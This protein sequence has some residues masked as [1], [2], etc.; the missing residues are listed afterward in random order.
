MDQLDAHHD[1]FIEESSGI[2]LVEADSAHL[3]CQMDDDVRF[4]LFVESFHIV[5]TN[6]IVLRQIGDRYIVISL[7]LESFNEMFPQEAFSAGEGN[8]FVFHRFLFF[9]LPHPLVVAC[10]VARIQQ[11]LLLVGHF[12]I[13]GDHHLYELLEGYL[14]L[15]V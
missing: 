6:Q 5:D 8:A 14:R 1:V 12:H 3:G 4:C 7:I 15:P 2:L 10:G 13:R 9:L 11:G